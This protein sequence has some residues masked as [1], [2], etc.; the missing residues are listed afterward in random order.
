MRRSILKNVR[1]L[2]CRGALLFL[3]LV[4][5]NFTACIDPIPLSNSDAVL[6]VITLA[7][8]GNYQVIEDLLYPIVIT[9]N[10]VSLNLNH[11]GVTHTVADDSVITINPILQEINV[12]N[13]RVCNVGFPLGAGAGIVVGYGASVISVH[14][15]TIE[16]CGYGIRF[17]GLD[18][19]HVGIS[20]CNKVNCIGSATGFC[21]EY[22]DE[23]VLSECS[24]L[25]CKNA[26]FTLRNSQA[27]CLLDCQSLTTTG[28]STVTAFFSD[29]GQCNLF[30]GCVA[31]QTKTS[32][33]TFGDKACGFVVT[34]T[35]QKTKIVDCI[36]NEIGVISS[37][38]AVTF[39]IQL[40]PVIQQT[41]DVLSTV[42]YWS[43]NGINDPYEVA[44]SPHNDYLAVTLRSGTRILIYKF[45]ATGM[46]L[47][48]SITPAASPSSLAWSPDG[49]YL[50]VG[51][52][53]AL[54]NVIVYSF[55]GQTLTLV[56]TYAGGAADPNS[57]TLS[58]V[59]SPNGKYIAYVNS[60]TGYVGI[61]SFDGSSLALV[62]F[63]NLS[64]TSGQG[65][66]AAWASDGSAVAAV[67]DS[68]IIPLTIVPVDS[69]GYLGTAVQL[70]TGHRG[71]GVAWSPNG[72]YFA[73]CDGTSNA[74]LVYRWLPTDINP[75]AQV[76]S[77]A[78]AGSSYNSV[79]W[80]PDGNYII[81]GTG[82]STIRLYQF[83][84]T[85][86]TFIKVASQSLSGTVRTVSWTADGRYIAAAGSVSSGS[87]LAV[88]AMYGPLNCL[89]DNC[90][91]CDV[92]ASNQNMGRGLAMG[93]TTIC[94]RTVACNNGVNYSYG[95]PNVYD[96]YFEISRDV[97]QP[98][99][100]ISMPT[101][102]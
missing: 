20:E 9:T 65:F 56:S 19:E 60:Y 45:D 17:A 88:T 35:E 37:P 77:I 72:K 10:N 52:D 102:L 101:T 49:K 62:S 23:T 80:S 7:A 22:S 76:A 2:F 46:S 25:C 57:K 6:G 59:W 83:T 33:V 42:T 63:F 87:L 53:A 84:G 1:Q 74:L 69:N 91:V 86:L 54:N 47:V 34:G 64:V 48:T 90:R 30:K 4:Y 14:D 32:S 97:V 31:K 81:A 85:G 29:A 71:Y 92:T 73:V 99:D 38:T 24:A 55:N 43:N 100:N 75:I 50:V 51:V 27:N 70:S 44:W 16:N 79:V 95:I 12:F 28:S 13:G 36:V 82:N 94:T 68:T 21:L 89:I 67:V 78:D 58:A 98:F 26:G 5:T 40:A 96:G 11:H 61:L 93:G 3:S 15:V 8:T 18:G 39:G 41:V 66:Y